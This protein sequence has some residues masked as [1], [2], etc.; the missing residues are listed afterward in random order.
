MNVS[1]L[2][3]GRESERILPGPPIESLAAGARWPPGTATELARTAHSFVGRQ[4][5]TVVPP[6]AAP[7]VLWWWACLAESVTDQVPRLVSFR[8]I[9][10]IVNVRLS[11][12]DEKHW[13][14]IMSRTS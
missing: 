4:L 3:W 10:V 5:V 1:R 12:L 9:L 2:Q 11:E 13:S 8:L 6:V 14:K 7:V